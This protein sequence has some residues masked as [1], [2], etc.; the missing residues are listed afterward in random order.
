MLQ[1][2]ID[3][4][5]IGWCFTIFATIAAVTVP[6]LLIEIKWGV[7]W[8]SIKDRK[9]RSKDTTIAQEVE[10]GINSPQNDS[11]HGD[12]TAGDVHEKNVER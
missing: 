3:R 12:V 8:R 5:G 7:E 2:I 10:G 1:I 9:R 11:S 4:I 6:L